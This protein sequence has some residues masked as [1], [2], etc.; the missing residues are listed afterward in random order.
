MQ[1]VFLE[2]KTLRVLFCFPPGGRVLS[3]MAH[4]VTLRPKV[5]S[6]FTYKGRDFTSF[7]RGLEEESSVSKYV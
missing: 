1:C 5:V 7:S 3:I 2:A 4:K 6:L